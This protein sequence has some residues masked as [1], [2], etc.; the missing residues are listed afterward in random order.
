MKQAEGSK[1]EQQQ[2]MVE[3]MGVIF[4]Q[5]GLR[6]MHGR[7]IAYLLL[8]EPPHKSFYDIQEFL[9]AS[10][11]TVSTALNFLIDQQVVEYITFSGDRRRYFQI[12]AEGWLNNIKKQIF[13]VTAI[14]NIFDIALEYR[15]ETKHPAFNEDLQLLIDFH[16][17]LADTLGAFI[18]KWETSSK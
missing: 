9:K 5:R 14:K 4:E 16:E 3:N 15:S 18:E 8:A 2:Q 6:P 11:S 10:K 17:Q 12:N 13:Q 7:V 1:I